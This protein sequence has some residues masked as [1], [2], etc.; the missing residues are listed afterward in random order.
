MLQSQ[1]HR[2]ILT[3]ETTL[4]ISDQ[5]PDRQDYKALGVAAAVAAVVTAAQLATGCSTW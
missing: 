2:Q 4:V 1:H 3:R 5:L